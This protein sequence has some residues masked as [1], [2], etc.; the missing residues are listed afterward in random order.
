MERGEAIISI[1]SEEIIE[2]IVAVF[3]VIDNREALE[4]IVETTTSEPRGKGMVQPPP[5]IDSLVIP[6]GLPIVVPRNLAPTTIPSNLPK[7][8]G[9]RNEDPSLYMERYVETL[10]SSLVTNQGY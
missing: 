7:F 1:F 4:T 9:S 5:R 2:D 10:T 3:E 8:Y 6:R